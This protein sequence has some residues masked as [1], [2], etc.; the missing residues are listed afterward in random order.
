MPEFER[1]RD[2]GRPRWVPDVE[3][4][5]EHTEAYRRGFVVTTEE[6]PLCGYIAERMTGV[7]IGDFDVYEAPPSDQ[8]NYGTGNP[9]Q[10][11]TVR[12]VR[13]GQE[14]FSAYDDVRDVVLSARRAVFEESRDSDFADTVALATLL[15]MMIHL[16]ISKT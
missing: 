10:D 6:M 3:R 11:G 5:W 13:R 14:D 12:L 2:Q 16:K 7:G 8:V 15:E 4:A 9:L 1:P